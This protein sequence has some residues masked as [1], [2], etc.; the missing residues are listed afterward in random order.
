MTTKRKETG[1]LDPKT[2]QRIIWITPP[3]FAEDRLDTLAAILREHFGIA[4]ERFVWP[5]DGT[6][7]LTDLTRSLVRQGYTPYAILLRRYDE[8]RDIADILTSLNVPMAT[9][10]LTQDGDEPFRKTLIECL[11][12]VSA[13]H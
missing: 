4:G 5:D 2:T 8:D 10:D 13:Y 1:M 9:I 12:L 3:C 6:N 11:R 7:T